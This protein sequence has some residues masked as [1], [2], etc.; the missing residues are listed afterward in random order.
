MQR[1]AIELIRPEMVS[2]MDVADAGGRILIRAGR[3]LQESHIQAMQNL[4]YGS[5]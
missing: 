1:L 5:A 4:G 2:A 3:P